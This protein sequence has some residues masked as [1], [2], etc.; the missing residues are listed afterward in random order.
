MIMIKEPE[1]LERVLA[2]LQQGMSEQLAR[3]ILSLDFT[4][5]DHDRYQALAVKANRGTLT[6]EEEIEL[7]RFLAVNDFLTIMKA[8]AEIF[9]NRKNPAA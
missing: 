5:R 3:G 4:S 8:E 7:D 1:L 6:P 2:P 9:L